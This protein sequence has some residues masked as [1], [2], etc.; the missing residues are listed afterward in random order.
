[1]R[2][3]LLLTSLLLAAGVVVAAEQRVAL[4]DGAGRDKVEA[5]CTACHSLD[6]ILGN[7]PF[8]NR[9]V[10]DAEVTKMIKAF[11]APISDADAKEIVDYLTK[12]YGT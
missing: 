8:M 5:N 10:W 11:G 9:T 2:A 3:T 7:S 12:N 6:Y 1:M 4:K